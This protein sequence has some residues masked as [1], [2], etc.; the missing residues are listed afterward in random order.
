MRNSLRLIGLA[1]SLSHPF[2]PPLWCEL[3][4]QHRQ[5]LLAHGSGVSLCV[6]M[7]AGTQSRE[8]DSVVMQSLRLRLPFG[9]ELLRL[10]CDEVRAFPS[11]LDRTREVDL[12]V[13]PCL[14]ERRLR[15][16]PYAL[17]LGHEW[18]QVLVGAARVLRN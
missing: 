2:G 10:L 5:R 3:Q 1:A 18:Q 6:G 16:A 7:L 11:R 17:P 15:L 8:R 9:D 12:R 4:V 14:H 13:L